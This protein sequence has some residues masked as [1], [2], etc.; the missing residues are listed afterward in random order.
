MS[1]PRGDGGRAAGEPTLL[2]GEDLRREAADR[3]AQEPACAVR[4]PPGLGVGKERA[5][6]QRVQESPLA[7]PVLLQDQH[8][9]HQRD[10]HRRP[11][12]AAQADERPGPRPTSGPEP[13]RGRRLGGARHAR[14]GFEPAPAHPADHEL[15][16]NRTR[17][18]PEHA[19]PPPAPVPARG[20]RW[21]P[22]RGGLRCALPAGHAGTRFPQGWFACLARES[23]RSI[24]TP[25]R[26]PA[27]EATARPASSPPSRPRASPDRR[28]RGPAR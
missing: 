22:P 18:A 7:D 3:P 4:K 1:A 20:D 2:H 17:V 8:A 25:S 12:E 15:Q 10:L 13:L 6:V 27:A 11:S 14:G 24:P 16:G 5:V 28:R 21:A 9:F 26:H 23:I 19:N